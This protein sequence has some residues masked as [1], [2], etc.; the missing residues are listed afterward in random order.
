MNLTIVFGNIS[1]SVWSVCG[2]ARSSVPYRN[3]L[4][5]LPASL[6]GG[7]YVTRVCILARQLISTVVRMRIARLTS[8]NFQSCTAS[9]AN[10]WLN[11]SDQVLW[12]K[13]DRMHGQCDKRN[14]FTYL[15]IAVSNECV[16]WPFSLASHKH[17][18]VWISTVICTLCSWSIHPFRIELEQLL[19]L[20]QLQHKFLFIHNRCLKRGWKLDVW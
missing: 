4:W 20:W 11:E 2:T 1:G 13:W 14:F 15:S 9:V 17:I 5:S 6:V 12:C 8:M 10:E 3:G 16:H 7:V 18:G 19:G